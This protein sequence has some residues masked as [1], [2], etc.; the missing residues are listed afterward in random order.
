[1]NFTKVF[2]EKPTTGKFA[3]EEQLLSVE[4]KARA[5]PITLY[6]GKQIQR[7]Q[8]PL[9]P[10]TFIAGDMTAMH[11]AMNQLKIKIP[12]PN[13]YPASLAP[14]M[15]RRVWITTLGSVERRIVEG[16]SEPLFVKPADRRKCFTG[17]IF[18][19]DQD[20]HEIG[21]ISRNQRVW[22]SE[23]VSWLSEFRVYV[24][25][26]QIVSIDHYSGSADIA[27]DP[28]TLDSALSAYHSSGEA[29]LA[30]GIDFG[31]LKYGQ[32]ALVE[33]ND[34]YALGAY[35]ISSSA[36]TDLLMTRWSELVSEI[37]ANESLSDAD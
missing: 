23:I 14:F 5:I 20:F 16:E 17:R 3:V 15:N 7:R 9:T 33:A 31:V 13:D 35:N 2:L 6:T 24:I 22:C 29:P 11:G 1:M 25:K 26:S 18:A 4:F 12:T 8:L 10:E 34:G 32:T 27:L 30:Y 36:Y 37:G 28:S 19:T 21:N